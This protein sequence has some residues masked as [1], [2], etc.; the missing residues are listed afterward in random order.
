MLKELRAKCLEL[1]AQIA[2]QANDV[3]KERL[4]AYTFVL[5]K[6]LQDVALSVGAYHM[7]TERLARVFSTV[8][9]GREPPK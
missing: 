6:V 9:H 8:L 1:P 2:L 7:T 3:W 5:L 4:R